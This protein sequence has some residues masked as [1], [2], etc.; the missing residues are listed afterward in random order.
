MGMML[1]GCSSD[2]I[3]GDENTGNGGFN[4]ADAT[5]S[6][7]TVTVVPSNGMG[8]RADA[9]YEDGDEI[10]GNVQSVRFFFFDEDGNAAPVWENRGTGS[11]NSYID[12]YPNNSDIDGS[13]APAETVETILHTTLSLVTPSGYSKPGAVLAVVNPTPEILALDDKDP[14]GSEIDINGPSLTTLKSQT[15]VADYLTGLTGTGDPQ[16]GNFVMSNSVY[17]DEEENETGIVDATVLEEK[18]FT[19]DPENQN[20]IT[21]IYVERVLARLDFGISDKMKGTSVQNGTIYKVGEYI[22]DKV[23]TDDKTDIDD[24]TDTNGKTGIYVK[25]L[26][27]NVTGTADKSRLVKSVNASWDAEDLFGT[28]T[29]EPWTTSDYHR[30]FW[31]INPEGLEYQY[32][33]FGHENSNTRSDDNVNPASLEIAEAGKYVTTYLQENANKYSDAAAAPEYATKVIIAAQLCNENGKPLEI[34]EWAYHKYSVEDLKKRFA[35]NELGQLYSGETKDGKTVYT[36]ITAADLDF[37]TA[38]QLGLETDDAKYYVYVV[39]SK[40]GEGK[41]WYL[42]PSTEEGVENESFDKKEEVQQYIYNCINRVRVW[43]NGMTYYYFDV[44]H[45]GN[46]GSPAEFGIVRNHIYRTTVTSVKGLGTP[47]YDPDQ[48]IKPEP[49]EYDESIVTADVKILQWRVV[50]NDYELN[51]K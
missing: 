3:V 45:L 32:G 41:T 2:A 44:K 47:V 12:W 20:T 6:Y 13:G 43:N 7:L 18:N 9:V 36:K 33:D 35:N 15:A 49:N 24:E 39:L 27:W 8:T 17:A 16:V 38:D 11:Y 25:F 1:A 23:N 5:R 48:I 37:K 26:G 34:A 42:N 4:P 46:A 40:Q 29:T 22:I 51:W 50:A 30:S 10:E 21:T 19:T 14:E 28:G 31:A